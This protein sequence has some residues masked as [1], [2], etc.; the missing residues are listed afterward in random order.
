MASADA[1]GRTDR[2]R[3]TAGP[4]SAPDTAPSSA[5]RRHLYTVELFGGLRLREAGSSGR[6]ITRFRTQKTASLFAY[7]AFFHDRLHTREVLI[8]RF[9]PEPGASGRMSLAV[10][11]SSLRS[12]LEPPGVPS[13][14][15][16]IA[17]RTHVGLNPEAVTTDVARFEA[18]IERAEGRGAGGEPPAEHPDAQAALLAEAVSL[19]RPDLLPAQYDEWVAPQQERLADR[20]RAA[21]AGLVRLHEG[22]G[23]LH[24]AVGFARL[25][26]HSDP[27]APPACAELL[28]LLQ[29]AGDREGA[30]AEAQQFAARVAAALGP[31]VAEEALLELA[32]LIG[33]LP[34][35]VSAAA[36]VMPA[37]AAKP[38]RSRPAARQRA[39]EAAVTPAPPP[40][41]AFAGGVAPPLPPPPTSVAAAAGDGG[42]GGPSVAPLPSPLTRFFG[43]D[44]DL[45]RLGRLTADPAVRLVTI[46]GPGGVGKTRFALAFARGL[47]DAG[48]AGPHDVFWATLAH[49]SEASLLPSALAEAA[50]ADLHK[51]SAAGG[52]GLLAAAAEALSAARR[53]VLV[54]DN[55][56]HLVEEGAPV[57][58]ELLLLVPDL[59]CV[60]TSRQRLGLVGLEREFPLGALPTPPIPARGSAVPAGEEATASAG[61]LPTAPEPRELLEWYPSVALFVDRAQ[62]ARTDFQITRRNAASIAELVARLEGIPLAIELAAARAQ[63]L[64]PQQMLAQLFLSPDSRKR[65]E[66]LVNRNRSR[67]SLERHRSLWATLAWS[68]D[69]LA[70]ELRGLFRALCVFRG[71]FDATSLE[72]V[73][74]AAGLGTP[75]LFVLD[76]LAQLCDAS[77]L[78]PVADEPGLSSSPGAWA[79]DDE[80]GDGAE[81][82]VPQV[83]FAML[84]TLRSFA[85]GQLRDEDG[86]DGWL[87][88]RE[89]HARHFLSL[90]ESAD[91][92]ARLAPADEA[93]LM[94]RLDRDAENLHAALRFLAETRS[95]V[96]SDAEE[97]PSL[98][99]RLSAS[100]SSYWTMRG[101]LAEGRHWLTAA[102]TRYGI[103]P[104]TDDAP[105]PA[106][107]EA[108]CLHPDALPV[109]AKALNKLAALATHQGDPAARGLLLQSL[110]LHERLGDRSRIASVL[111]NLAILSYRAGEL[112]AAERF[113]EQALPVFRELG[114]ERYA[115]KV[116]LN[117]AALVAQRG[118]DR[119]GETFTRESMG[120]AQRCGDRHAQAL[121]LSSLCD[122]YERRG[123]LAMAERYGHEALRIA[124]EIKNVPALSNVLLNLATVAALGGDEVRSDRLLVAALHA[125]ATHGMFLGEDFRTSLA[126]LRP[127]LTDRLD[128]ATATAEELTA[129][130]LGRLARTNGAGSATPVP[131]TLEE[132]AE[133]ALRDDGGVHAGAGVV[134]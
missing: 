95:G 19:Y 85:E 10:S 111:N 99:A 14:S 127:E 100:L 56:E 62:A 130:M 107:E 114:Q 20:Y 38:S 6:V 54:L 67:V 9:W 89:A 5:S 83:R 70:P 43:R 133:Y 4:R 115:G 102:V 28:R 73:I 7:L 1:K 64:T 106:E 128:P 26:A 60:L 118:D 34:P 58:E 8:E 22:A 98:L 124:H 61:G 27:L 80:F 42:S 47:R 75:D 11:L 121:C 125:Y 53:P 35:G 2:Q 97:A 84:E 31:D 81:G 109:A 126:S 41:T 12:Q 32:G 77:L 37:P 63:V 3:E 45:T 15:V 46:T 36:A 52:S 104:A 96:R 17:D 76:G 40:E 122:L 101:R 23:R 49:L 88:L 132:A 91:S 24:E 29:A 71:S 44:G 82:A 123:D 74:A 55:F 66:L 50:G 48:A 129:V 65:F 87:A 116:L 30:A 94:E 105:R 78:R 51:A 93:A 92:Q 90:A 69:L 59:T 13:K 25:A 86:E 39:E 134:R 103:M 113:Y 57:V 117:I 131:M 21:V 72:E 119:R 68:Y 110:A 33:P 18:L 79:A 108:D 120:I 112:D 16:L